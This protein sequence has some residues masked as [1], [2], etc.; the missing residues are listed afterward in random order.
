MHNF[1]LSQGV[2][3]EVNRKKE[4]LAQWEAQ[5]RQS[6]M[7]FSDIVTLQNTS[8]RSLHLTLNFT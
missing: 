6:Q 8:G 3:A 7:E 5:V 4:R 2:S 1:S